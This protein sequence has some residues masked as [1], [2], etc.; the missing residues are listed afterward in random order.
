MIRKIFKFSLTKRKKYSGYLWISPFLIGFIFVYLAP[1]IQSIQFSLSE[2]E[3]L[4]HGFQLNFV[5]FKNFSYAFFVD[6]EF[7][8]ILVETIIEVIAE[9]P[10]IIIFSFFL[11]NIL[12]QKFRGRLFFRVIFFLPVILTAGVLY[13]LEQ[14]DLMMQAMQYGAEGET[15]IL[16]EAMARDFLLDLHL[17]EAFLEYIIALTERI[18]DIINASAIPILIF[19]AGLQS[20]PS[21][22]YEGAKIEGATSWEIFWKITFPLI[23][24]LFLTNIIFIIINSFTTP[25]N[26]LVGHIDNTAWGQGIYGVSVAMSLIYFI[27]IGIILMFLGWVIEKKVVYMD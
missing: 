20:I 7:L 14:N 10:A 27:C 2:V 13:E 22:L 21:S 25:G 18:P 11:A 24:P 8:R 15:E 1:I 26:E 17:P 9:I 12:N 23:S 6:P 4:S 16:G 3:V 5:G 19:L